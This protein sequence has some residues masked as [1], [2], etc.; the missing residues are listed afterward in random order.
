MVWKCGNYNKCF[1]SEKFYMPGG[2][3][4]FGGDGPPHPVQGV[5]YPGGG[6]GGYELFHPEIK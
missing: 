5:W 3:G 2:G 4:W 1:S 6:G